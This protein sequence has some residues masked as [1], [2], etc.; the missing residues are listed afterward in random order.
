M[1]DEAKTRVLEHALAGAKLRERFFTE[2]ADLV[3]EAARSLAICIA[4]GGKLL[5]CGNGGSAADAQHLAA[6]FVNRFVLDRPPL[7]AIAL[8][9][10]T[11]ALTAIGND[12][13]FDQ[14]FSKQVHALGQPGDILVGISSSGNS[15]NVIK[16]MQVARENGVVT[17]GFTGRNGGKMAALSDILINV[18]DES[19]ALVQEIHIAVGHLLCGLV[20]YYLFQNAGALTPY[21]EMEDEGNAGD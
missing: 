12:F 3:V 8:T 9:T 14:V 5:F 4:R 18:P 1:S 2:N 6:E 17:M 10:D 20:D 15:E 11:S 16:A 19:T 13:G 21:L 7:P